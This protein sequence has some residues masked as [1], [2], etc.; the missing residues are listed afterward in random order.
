MTI[1]CIANVVS[2]SWLFAGRH[3]CVSDF[4]GAN[5]LPP[6]CALFNL[7][8]LFLF[9]QFLSGDHVSYLFCRNESFVLLDK[10]MER[11]ETDLSIELCYH[12]NI[13]FHNQ[14]YLPS[15]LLQ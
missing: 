6:I 10:Q 13:R 14:H 5:I 12:I 2:Y 1:P 9:S 11:N 7:T 15:S 3:I 8:Y 4:T